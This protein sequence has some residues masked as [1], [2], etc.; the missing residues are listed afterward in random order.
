[1]YQLFDF[2]EFNLTAYEEDVAISVVS[3]VSPNEYTLHKGTYTNRNGIFLNNLE[4]HTPKVCLVIV[5]WRGGAFQF[6]RE[7]T[8]EMCLTSI[9]QNSDNLKIRA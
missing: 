5:R 4:M 6:V 9:K 7:Q 2:C 8:E 3:E 1:M